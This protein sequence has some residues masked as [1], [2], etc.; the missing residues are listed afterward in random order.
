MKEILKKIIFC[1]SILLFISL[2]L[3]AQEVDPDLIRSH[4]KRIIL[5][6][7]TES[8]IFTIKSKP[9][10][11]INI[12]FT[13]DNE[14]FTD[15]DKQTEN[16]FISDFL[17]IGKAPGT[18]ADQT[19]EKKYELTLEEVKALGQSKKKEGYKIYF[20]ALVLGPEDE[21]GE[22]E[23]THWSFS[24][25]DWENAPFVLVFKTHQAEMGYDCFLKGEEHFKQGEYI[26]AIEE[27]ESA[28]FY[29]ADP[30]FIY[31]I[32]ICHLRLATAHI[33]EFL[34]Y[35]EISEENSAK[36]QNLLKRLR[37]NR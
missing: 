19:V 9:D 7:T 34:E 13:A 30:V 6:K 29:F 16:N 35:E 15:F 12:E 8:L 37:G 24:D 31:N 14:L 3:A 5:P 32:G 22:S 36:A 33:E 25:E 2:K 27:Y 28:F 10:T 26:K 18:P 21:E 1:I 17:I 11:A 4:K 20:R 23:V